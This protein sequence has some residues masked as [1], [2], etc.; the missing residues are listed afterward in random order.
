MRRYYV[1]GLLLAGIWMV[2]AGD[3]ICLVQS[4][5]LKEKVEREV[6]VQ[7]EATIRKIMEVGRSNNQVMEHLDILSNRIGARLTGS[8]TPSSRS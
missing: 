7:D 5:T 4:Q 8:I 1:V 6:S 3:N 2:L